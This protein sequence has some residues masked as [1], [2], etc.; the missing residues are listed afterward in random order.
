MRKSTFKQLVAPFYLMT[1]SVGFSQPDN[2]TRRAEIVAMAN[3]GLCRAGEF[4]ADGKEVAFVSN[5]SGSP[6]IWKVSSNGGW[7]TQLTAFNDP[8]TAMVPAPKG[9]LIAF[10]LAPGG[11][12]NVQIYVMKTDGSGI[13][14]VTRGGKTNNFLG[15]WS[16]DGSLLSFGSNEQNPA[17]VDFFVYDIKK[18]SYDLVVKNKGTGGIVDFSLDNKQVLI[19][20]LASRGSNDLYMYDMVAKQEKLLT[21]H[22]GPGTFFGSIAPSGDVYLGSNK[23]RDLIAFGRHTGTAIEILSE[24]K[25]AEL[26][27]FALSNAGSVAA[28]SWNASG[29]TKVTL[30]DLKQRK[31]I[32]QLALPVELAGALAFSP[33][34]QSIVFT[35]QGAT[36]ASNIWI[37]SMSAN[38][39]RKIT[40]SPHPGVDLTALIAPELVTFKSFDGL[41]LSGWLYKPKTSAAPYPTVIS[42]HGGPEGQSVPGFNATAQLLAKEGIA[43]FLPNVRGSSGF[44][45]KF[46]NLDN[47]A[48]RVNGVK[49]IKGVTDHL[50]TSGIS[51]KDKL[52]IIGGSYGGYMVMAGVTEYPDM[53]A[54]GANLFGVVNFE[55]FF[56]HTEPWMAAISTVEYGD[57]ATQAEMLRQL[58]PIHKANVVKT[59]LLVEHGANDTNVP[60]IEAEQVVE[61]LKKNNVPV[62]YTLFPDEGHGWQKTR[63][64]I[65][66]TVEI[67]EWFTSYLK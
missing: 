53:F 52:G 67:V 5:L 42:Y 14:Q 60:V 24:Q 47:G 32:R 1:I 44:G 4:L 48:L 57:P 36:E 45:K 30:F 46:V 40:D 20:R 39:F 41:E 28:L 8:V 55:T 7:P 15:T 62:Q 37:Y 21:Q 66:S 22:D 13:K 3:I 43:F 54:A 9:D 18:G 29:K 25:G 6:Q 49:D 34:D 63:N 38:Q 50:V 59:P 17:G 19:T 12:L 27:G 2:D 51:R 23:D 10:A 31:E 26:N 64:R 65:T 16:K 11:G 61:A 35:G 58:S 56:K 33:D